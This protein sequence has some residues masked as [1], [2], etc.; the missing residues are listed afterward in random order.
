MNDNR[1]VRVII[2]H[3]IIIKYNKDK[4]DLRKDVLSMEGNLFLVNCP[5]LGKTCVC[6]G[7]NHFQSICLNK[8]KVRIMDTQVMDDR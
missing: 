1:M 8:N 5:V 4:K 2:F 6:G 7:I 3:F